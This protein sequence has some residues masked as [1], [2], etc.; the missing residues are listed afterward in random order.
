[1][2]NLIEN[3]INNRFLSLTEAYDQATKMTEETG[4]LH[5]VGI[6]S[7]KE[8]TLEVILAPKPRPETSQEYHL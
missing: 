8:K 3:V 1:M 2:I 4:K 6:A 5:Y 7:E